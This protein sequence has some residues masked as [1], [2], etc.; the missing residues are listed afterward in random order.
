ML[1]AVLAALPG[2]RALALVRGV[3]LAPGVVI[4]PGT[5][6]AYVARPEGGLV[7]VDLVAGSQRWAS[8]SAA[9]PLGLVDGR[10]V[11]LGESSDG[12]LRVIGFDSGTGATIATT[13]ASLPAG[14]RVHLADR[15]GSSFRAVLLAAGGGALIAWQAE[16][17]DPSPLAPLRPASGTDRRAQG[18]WSRRTGAFSLQGPQLA[19]VPVAATVSPTFAD[20]RLEEL[21]AEPPTGPDAPRTFLSADGAYRL[22]SGERVVETGPPR[23][24]WTIADARG[25]VLGSLLADIA[26]APFVVVDDTVLW[27][28]PA[29]AERIEGSWREFPRALLAYGLTSGAQIWERA[30]RDLIYRGP[31]PP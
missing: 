30:A 17:R 22:R 26:A 7:A 12:A 29:R 4:D 21:A 16:S 10:L 28:R 14:V 18:Q 13:D 25:H 23:Y 27:V 5:A 3:V 1:V 24:D 31:V 15:P 9:L 6:T 20:S 2:G 19:L 8:E 11:A